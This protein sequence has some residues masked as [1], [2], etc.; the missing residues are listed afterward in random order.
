MYLL[1]A[2]SAREEIVRVFSAGKG[3]REGTRRKLA[4]MLALRRASAL[5]SVGSTGARLLPRQ[6]VR[7]MGAGGPKGYGS[8]EYRGLKIA[9]PERWQSN[10]ATVYATMMWLW[11]IHRAR[12]DGKAL[13]VRQAARTRSGRVRQL[14]WVL[15]AERLTELTCA[16]P[17]CAGS[18]ASLGRASL[19]CRCPPV[20][21]AQPPRLFAASAMEVLSTAPLCLCQACVVNQVIVAP[22]GCPVLFIETSFHPNT[23]APRPRVGPRDKASD[24]GAGGITTQH[25]HS[26]THTGVTHHSVHSPVRGSGLITRVSSF[27]CGVYRYRADVSCVG[28]CGFFLNKLLIRKKKI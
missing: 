13:L 14:S 3:G 5:R 18:R 28:Y 1:M 6:Q 26:H 12:H 9:K 17:L 19:T 25:T 15:R 11:I 27:A 10:V 7:S 8:G 22:R 16:V 21:C 2:L 20:H 24:R 4:S 23:Q